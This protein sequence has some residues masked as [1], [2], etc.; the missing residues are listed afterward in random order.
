MCLGKY[1]FNGLI[2]RSVIFR[3]V[4]ITLRSLENGFWKGRV[5]GGGDR[6]VL[7]H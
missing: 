6:G 4:Q 3:K 7:G 5:G 2:V 1:D